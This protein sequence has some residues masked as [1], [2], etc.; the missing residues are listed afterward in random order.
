[1]KIALK[2]NHG[3]PAKVK[4]SVRPLKLPK[5][6]EPLRKRIESTVKP[7]L[8][9]KD[10]AVGKLG[11]ADDFISEFINGYCGK[12]TFSEQLR[13]W[14]SKVGGLPYLPKN[15]EYP[16]DPNGKPLS[17][18]AQINF[19]DVPKLDLF[20]EKGILQIYLGDAGDYLC[21][22]N[23][24]DRTDQSYFRVLFFPEVTYDKDVLITDFEFL[25]RLPKDDFSDLCPATPIKFDLRYEPISASDYRFNEQ[26]IFGDN[27]DDEIVDIYRE[28]FRGSGS[29]I[30]GYPDFVQSDPRGSE[31]GDDEFILLMQFD[32]DFEINAWG[33]GF[34]NFFIR[35]S[36]LLKRD[37][38][39][40]MYDWGCC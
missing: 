4:T 27:E 11:F 14:Q 23:Y 37:F 10:P 24:E 3:A 2:G 22:I 7:F 20:P 33:D 36:D 18:L 26:T 30:G 39:K 21:G 38:S 31:S 25:N 35:K 29:K 9:M 32:G 28:K 16:T 12:R 1:M 34:G 5:Q 17:L 6:L 15:H 13:L 19:A 8:A 40:V